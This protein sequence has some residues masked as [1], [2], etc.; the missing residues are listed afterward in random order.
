[1]IVAFL[2]DILLRANHHHSQEGLAHG[3]SLLRIEYIADFAL[4]GLKEFDSRFVP[5]N[6]VAVVL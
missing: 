5:S 2:H 4:M 3:Q 1:M 6:L